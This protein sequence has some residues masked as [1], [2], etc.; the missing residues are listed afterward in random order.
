MKSCAF[1]IRWAFVAL[2]IV[3]SFYAHR[4]A[5]LTLPVPWNDEAWHAWEGHAFARTG[6]LLSPEINPERPTV[7]KGHGYSVFLGTVF[8]IFGF[9]LETGRWSSWF[10][11][12][13][14]FLGLIAMFQR[15]PRPYLS[16]PVIAL[17]FLGSSYVVA[18]NVLRED[19]LTMA[20]AVSGFYA[21]VVGRP[22]MS[23]GLAGLA[24]VVHPNGIYFLAPVLSVTVY[25]ALRRE[26]H[27]SRI[28]LLCFIACS[29]GVL[30]S[31]LFVLRH[32]DFFILDF[33]GAGLGVQ[34]QRDPLGSISSTGSIVAGAWFAILFLWSISME[35]RWLLPLTFGFCCL[36]PP[37]LNQE[38]WYSVYRVTAFMVL[39]VVTT[40][41]VAS[42]ADRWF[43]AR[44][45]AFAGIAGACAAL[46]LLVF[47]L[48]HGFIE[49]PRNYPQDMTWG[50][51]M[52]MMSED[53]PYITGDDIREVSEIIRADI[54]DLEGATAE[55]HN[56]GGD[57]V[58]FKK[59]L[60]GIQIRHRVY[61]ESGGHV[62]VFHVSR[63]QPEWFRR[64]LIEVIS[65]RG[66]DLEH[67]AYVRDETEKWYVVPTEMERK[68]ATGSAHEA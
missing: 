14:I 29:A 57:S 67:P 43:P 21:M 31:G 66:V 9:S 10:C 1:W 59:A 36:A 46:P 17:F 55:F 26:L 56:L 18:G 32:W 52:R 60:E 68:K 39:V 13:A 41:L 45:K 28:D 42:A 40:Q 27:V 22:V 62:M 4:S 61:T 51:G 6:T 11:T 20:L 5:G 58:F 30:A 44:L 64:Q 38:M 49:G 35:R 65:S 7:F 2:V 12:V 54:G 16:L 23:V 48:R 3:L 34:S 8:R 50:W 37:I 25:Q 15:L 24:V 47:S 63:Y 19:T 33:F 53:V